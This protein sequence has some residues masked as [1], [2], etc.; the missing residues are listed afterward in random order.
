MYE[1]SAAFWTTMRGGIIG[2][3]GQALT[4]PGPG[5]IDASNVIELTPGGAPVS[6]AP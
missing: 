3:S 2:G 4:F 5:A 1:T 6:C